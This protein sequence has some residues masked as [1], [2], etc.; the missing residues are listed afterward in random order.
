MSILKYIFA[1]ALV[2]LPSTITAQTLREASDLR[3]P[4]GIKVILLENHKAPLISFQVWYR[5]GSRF[6]TVGKT[7]L[8]HLLEHMMF[9]GTQKVSGEDFTRIINENGGEQ[10]AFT[11]HDF[12][13]YFETLS[14]DHIGLSL[15]LESDRMSNLVLRESDFK[16]ERMVVIE[17]RRMRTDDNPQSAL[18]EQLESAAF[19]S[20]PYHWPV[21]GWVEDIERIKLEDVQGFY[22]KYYNPA[23]AIIVIVGDFK[24]DALIQEVEKAF[25]AISGPAAPER[26][27]VQDPPQQGERRLIVERPAHVGEVVVGYHVPNLAKP[28]AYVLEVIKAVLSS[29]K[30]SR[31]YNRLVRT[32]LALEASADYSMVSQDPP[33]FYVSATYL[34]NKRSDEVEK[35]LY[36]ELELLKNVPV[37]PRELEKAKNQLEASFVFDQDSIFYLGMNLAS[38]EIAQDWRAIGNYIPSIRSVTPEEIRRVATR[39]FTPE[40]RTVGILAPTAPAEGAPPPAMGGMKEKAIR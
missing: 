39:Y 37:D 28:D 7:G 22:K 19:Q 20:Q 35:A 25:G 11:S 2:L 10:N 8:A 24:K 31:F 12:A 27:T 13:A 18:V 34:P 1:L 33:L 23:N 5:A 14:S 30:S 3:L 4:N 6:E 9:K 36:S 15:M 38:Y 17:E 29:G 26:F 32:A 40:N 16:T 21:I